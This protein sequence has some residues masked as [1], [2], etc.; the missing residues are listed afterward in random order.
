MPDFGSLSG[1]D[2]LQ[3]RRSPVC[4]TI[5]LYLEGYVKFKP[6]RLGFE[7]G[8]LCLFPTTVSSTPKYP[9]HP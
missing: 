9:L 7:L 5:Y 8:S 3:K 1:E 2:L 4:P 6:P